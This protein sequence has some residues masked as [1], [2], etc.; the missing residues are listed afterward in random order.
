VIENRR[1]YLTAIEEEKLRFI[2]VTGELRPRMII[3]FALCLSVA[4]LSIAAP[5]PAQAEISGIRVQNLTDKCAWI[6]TYASESYMPWKIVGTPQRV[7]PHSS[8][9]SYFG[10]HPDVKV[11]AEV[12]ANPDCSGNNIH[13]TYDIIKGSKCHCTGPQ[14]ST[15]R[16]AELMK[17]NN[18]YNIWFKSGV[19]F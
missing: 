8:V 12:K 13:D 14:T 3:R 1:D 15:G 5:R 16:I 4:L 19:S 10:Y 2:I 7:K 17:T 6:T 9:G 11:R 18:G